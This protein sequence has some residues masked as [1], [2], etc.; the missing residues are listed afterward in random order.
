MLKFSP[1]GAVTVRDR[2]HKVYEVEYEVGVAESEKRVA[3]IFLLPVWPLEPPGR[4]F[5]LILLYCRCIAHKRL[6]M[7]SIR[8][9]GAPNLNLW[10]GNTIWKPKVLTKVPEMVL[11][12]VKL[13]VIRKTRVKSR[14]GQR[15]SGFA[16]PEVVVY[17]GLLFDK[18]KVGVAESKKRIAAIFLLTVW[19]LE[20]PGRS[21]LPYS[22]LYCR[23]IAHRRLEMLSIRTPGAQNLN[24]GPEVQC[25]NQKYF[26]KYRKWSEMP[27]N[28][29]LSEKCE[30]KIVVKPEV[31]V[32][33]GL[34][35]V[36]SEFWVAE[37]EKRVA[38]IFL[39]P[40]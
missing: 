4:S 38:A 2:P 11:N 25:R 1:G 23:R 3:A 28:L 13:T 5:C 39:L 12:V 32:Y 18:S 16:K 34:L 14:R 10:P 17:F 33:F 29:F 9:P 21:F 30:R 19:P 31:V 8:K 37:S 35:L 36:K 26:Q 15:W 40:V 7:L 20:P 22:G 27:W 6:E 24:V